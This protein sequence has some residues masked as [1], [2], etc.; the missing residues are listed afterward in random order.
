[1][2]RI[3]QHD[4]FSA[5]AAYEAAI[6]LAPERAPLRLWYAGFLS[7]YLS[8]QERAL[9]HLLVANKIAPNTPIIKL[10]TARIMQYLRRFQ[11]AENHLSSIDDI[12][13]LPAKTRRVHLDLRLQGF[14]RK[15]EYLINC[16]SFIDA[17]MALDMARELLENAPKALIDLKTRQSIN[18]ARRLVPPLRRAFKGLSE[19]NRLEAI[20]TYFSEIGQSIS[21]IDNH[22]DIN[23]AQ[24]AH[25]DSKTIP[26]DGSKSQGVMSELHPN[27]AFIATDSERFFFHRGEWKDKVDYLIYGEGYLVEFEIGRNARGVCALNVKPLTPL[28]ETKGAVNSFTGKVKKIEKTFGFIKTDLGRDHFFHKT[29]CSQDHPFEIFQE[30]AA[31]SFLSA[32]GEDGRLRAVNIKLINK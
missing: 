5:E 3:A 29:D 21:N 26:M 19:Q 31:V 23:S 15:A 14:T 25:V 6:S 22:I 8:D 9:E 11:E 7:R 12:D 20:S 16:E 2:L 30:G 1:M 13:Q 10:E 17:L 32:K 4:V 27:F 28:L 24:E 18:R